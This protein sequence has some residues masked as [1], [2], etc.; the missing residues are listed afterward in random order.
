MRRMFLAT[1]MALVCCLV[2]QAQPA[3]SGSPMPTT[4]G[5]GF[6]GAPYS[7]LE[8]TVT[9]LPGGTVKKFESRLW[10]DA[11]GRTREERLTETQNGDKYTAV[12]IFDPIAGVYYKWSIG[13]RDSK[14]QL[15][16]WPTRSEQRVTAPA[17]GSLPPAPRT[18]Y[19]GP[20]CRNQPFDLQEINGV[21]AIG[22]RTERTIAAPG[23]PEV[24]KV[25]EIWTSPDLRIIVRHIM[26]DPVTGRTETNLTQISR[27]EPKADLFAPPQGYVVRDMRV[28][29]QQPDGWQ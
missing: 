4:S 5:M 11:Q 2:L 10:R 17:A 7:A 14:R 27:E 16:I 9:T 23:R 8:T 28:A 19:C 6:T 24:I 29:S 13:L 1:F 22:R 21:M 15:T 18:E 12:S 20:G 26:E 25:V 3:P